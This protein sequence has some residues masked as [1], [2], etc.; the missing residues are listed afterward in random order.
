MSVLAKWKKSD[1]VSSVNRELGG[2]WCLAFFC[3]LFL[4]TSVFGLELLCY[5]VCWLFAVWLLLFSDDLYPLLGIIPML[6]YTPSLANNPG[7]N[8]DSVFYPE[9]GL[10]YIVVL[11]VTFLVLFLARVISDV[12]QG[13]V[14]VR[15][16]TLTVGF[17]LLGAAYLLGGVGYE[18]YDGRTLAFGALEI[19]SLALVYFLFTLFCDVARA[20]KA[21]FAWMLFFG[22]VLLF[23]ETLSVYTFGEVFAN[24]SPVR[25]QIYTGWGMYNNLG[26]AL[27]MMM[28]GAFYLA[29]VHR[30]G[31]AFL[32]AGYAFFGAV[33]LTL[34]RTSIAVGAVIAVL[35]T[36]A[37]LIQSRGAVRIWNAV[38][39]V[40]AA[41]AAAALCYLFRGA[42]L[43]LVQALL[44]FEETGSSRLETYREGWEL[45][46]AHPFFGTGFYSCEQY[47]W[48]KLDSFIPPR[49]HNTYVQL[50][51]AC[52]I[53]GLLAYLVHRMETLVLLFRAP[54]FEKWM[55]ALSVLALIAT[56]WLDCH[57]FNLG[58]GLLYSALL[59]FAEKQFGRREK[60]AP[61]G[62]IG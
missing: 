47:K 11:I 33:V 30:A 61:E 3:L 15:F 6:Y 25:G 42:V 54:C 29:A 58:P 19:L 2:V 55:I 35:G 23:G 44:N 34:S 39:A 45:F 1:L 59:C 32:L 41:S 26:A 37:V 49:W 14:K 7:R 28:P 48:G 10:V 57:F 24:G 62:G 31:P 18:D 21:Y 40:L 38:L 20:P 53:V 50:L 51:A 56:S 16:P 17:V 43:S 22:G 13:N 46:R 60:H 36:A 8:P 27:C 9:N 4:V 52:G 5:T 12:R